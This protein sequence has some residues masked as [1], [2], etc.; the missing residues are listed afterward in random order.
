MGGLYLIIGIFSAN[1][2]YGNKPKKPAVDLIVLKELTHKYFSIKNKECNF[3]F[4]KEGLW[5]MGLI[6]Y[7]LLGKNLI[8][9]NLKN[10]RKGRN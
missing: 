5:G 4:S 2:F 10:K 8:V 1:S 9:R 3:C 7:L 6:S